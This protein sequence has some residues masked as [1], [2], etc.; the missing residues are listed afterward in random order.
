MGQA[1]KVL[2]VYAQPFWRQQGLSGLGISSFGPV[3]QFHDA[4]PADGAVGALFG[5][6]DNTSSGRSL[7]P[8]DR[9][10]AVVRQAVRMFGPDAAAVRHYAEL[11]WAREPFTTCPRDSLLLEQEHPQYGH[12]LLQSPQMNGRLHWAGTETSP[13]N[14]GY[15]DGAVYSGQ[16]VAFR[17][18]QLG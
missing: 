1:M 3:A 11:N 15:L 12:P 18:L 6:L 5:W 7:T 2:L 16:S 17:V 4:S 14:G 10:H 13:V 9:Q 8:A